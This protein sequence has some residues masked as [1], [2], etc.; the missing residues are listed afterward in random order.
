MFVLHKVFNQR[1]DENCQSSLDICNKLGNIWTESNE[2]NL[3]NLQRFGHKNEKIPSEMKVALR[4]KLFALF[5]LLHWLHC[6][7]RSQCLHCFLFKQ[8][9]SKLA[10]MPIYIIYKFYGFRAK[11]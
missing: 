4:Y 9:W 11:C 5:T 3:T 10:I 7:H 2:G 6:F 8:P 1:F